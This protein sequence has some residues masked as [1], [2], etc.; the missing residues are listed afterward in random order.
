MVAP[1][2]RATTALPPRDRHAWN[3]RDAE[4][5]V[6]A[7]FPGGRDRE[8][9]ESVYAYVV[10][11]DHY[12]NAKHWKGAGFTEGGELTA[13]AK[14]LIKQTMAPVPE[15][16]ARLEQRV[17]GICANEASIS[18]EPKEPAGPE[19]EDGKRKPSAEQEAAVAEWLRETT[20]WWD[21]NSF[22]G[23]KDI[24]KPTG[25]RGAVAMA[26]MSKAGS[27]CLRVFWPPDSRTETVRIKNAAGEV[28]REEKRV[29]RQRDRLAAGKHVKVVALPP[30]RCGVY[31]DPDTLK[32]TAVFLYST[33]DNRNAA[34]IWFAEGEKTF[35]RSVTEGD[36][37]TEK[38]YPLGGLLPIAQIDLGC[39]LTPAMVEAQGVIDTDNTSLLRNGVQH[40]YSQRTET[41][42]E[43]DG[44]WE[45]TPPAGITNPRTRL[46][47]DGVTLEY[48]HPGVAVLGAGFNR[49]VMG[50]RYPTHTDA[51]NI[52]HYALAAPGV[53]Y[54]EPS[55]SDSLIATL[56]KHTM[57]LR[58]GCHQ[59]HVMTGLMGGTAEA[60]G[61]AYEQK[62]APHVVDIKAGG[63]AVDA[64]VAHILLVGTVM[65]DYLCGVEDAA[66]AR[67]YTVKAQSHPSAGA[68]STEAQRTNRENQQAG[69]ISTPEA[70][71]RLG[72]QD[73]GAEIERIAAD[74]ALAVEERR[75]SVFEKAVNSGADPSWVMKRLGIPEME[76]QMALRS[77]GPPNIQQ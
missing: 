51:D 46:N 21:A 33:T 60:S 39:L 74:N 69:L 56:D 29:P 23:G 42:A 45:N 13:E 38:E 28:V 10:L 64:A 16:S 9:E 25:V 30:E 3:L 53:T 71:A 17:N 14:A 11:S 40:G 61:D 49:R 15:L 32:E 7:N 52:T 18:C 47:V 24:R 43:E 22:W 44:T 65:K 1:V 50:E 55:P 59:G 62:R 5:A 36:E 2:S 19:G 73:V 34:E 6:L 68:P 48:F 26:S 12:Q 54:H 75:W 20:F 72:I 31:K 70:I 66:F 27:A 63:E 37:A 77:D 67:A 57:Q 8:H 41:N 58:E 4:N 35:L 76:V